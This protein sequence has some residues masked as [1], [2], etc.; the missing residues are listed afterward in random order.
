[1]SSNV[2]L[3]KSVE[4]TIN[5]LKKLPKP[6]AIGRFHKPIPPHEVIEMVQ[7]SIKGEGHDI[8]Q[9]RIAIN[10]KHTRV[11]ATFDIANPNSK[12]K[13]KNWSAGIMTSTDRTSALKMAGGSRILVCDN[14]MVMGDL[15]TSRRKHT[16]GID[17]EGEVKRMMDEVYMS[18][19]SA[20]KRANLEE[21]VKIEE[22]GE[23]FSI[24]GDALVNKLL[25]ADHV[26]EAAQMWLANELEDVKSRSLWGIH[27]AF[28]RQIQKLNPIR[29]LPASVNI[30]KFIDAYVPEEEEAA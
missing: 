3:T 13:N 28:T 14:L 7:K 26:R 29:Q 21:A 16:S 22:E 5:D 15:I 24:I 27:N 6:T 18:C 20:D 1:M 11:M 4:I 10:P 8:V 25:P 9:R 17:L 2:I 12:D 19:R 30:A 23:F